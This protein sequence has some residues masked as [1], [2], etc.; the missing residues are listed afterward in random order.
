MDR[1][2]EAYSLKVLKRSGCPFL[3]IDIFFFQRTPAFIS[4][5][6]ADRGDNF[7]VTT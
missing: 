5:P 3:N 4:C 7:E 1:K 2:E 6:T